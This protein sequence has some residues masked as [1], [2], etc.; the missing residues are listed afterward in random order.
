MI[1]KISFPTSFPKTNTTPKKSGPKA[2]PK[3]LFVVDNK[4]STHFTPPIYDIDTQAKPN[5]IMPQLRNIRVNGPV[6]FTNKE[7]Q[8]RVAHGPIFAP[9][10]MLS[11]TL[12]NDSLEVNDHILADQNDSKPTAIQISINSS[13]ESGASRK[14]TY[15]RSSPK[16]SIP[17][18][19]RITFNSNNNNGSSKSNNNNSP[20]KP[21]TSTPIRPVP[22]SRPT[23]RK[24]DNSSANV[25]PAKKKN[26]SDV[27]V[28]DDTTLDVDQADDDSVVFVSETM[29]SSKQHA[30]LAR[31][32]RQRAA[33]YIPIGENS[34]TRKSVSRINIE[35]ILIISFDFEKLM[36]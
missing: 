5:E 26:V 4:P 14:V 16:A 8:N 18:I 3:F 30:M 11:S 28:L 6:D 35:N 25:K 22:T 17:K 33:N 7:N 1:A 20:S 9:D 31:S 27:I 36:H 24:A 23:K 12:L 10:P 15:N 21:I 32:P 29:V 19:P 34:S 13:C 2:E